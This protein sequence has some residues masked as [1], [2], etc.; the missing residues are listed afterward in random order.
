MDNDR[1]KAGGFLKGLKEMG[2]TVARQLVD[3]ISPRGLIK[4]AKFAGRGIGW[5]ARQAEKAP[6]V[7][8]GIKKFNDAVVNVGSVASEKWKGVK[9]GFAKTVDGT[10]ALE[11]RLKNMK[12]AVIHM[13]LKAADIL[14][15]GIENETKQNAETARMA[16]SADRADAVK[17]AKAAAGGEAEKARIGAKELTEKI[18]APGTGSINV[19]AQTASKEMS[20]IAAKGMTK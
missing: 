2:K 16:A 9:R 18:A 14:L 20:G 1:S 13:V 6:L 7:G 19:A 17:T 8:K 15:K 4:A 5:I 12:E 10:A 3:N 11:M